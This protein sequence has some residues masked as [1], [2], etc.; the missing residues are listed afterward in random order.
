[1]NDFHRIYCNQLLNERPAFERQIQ[2]IACST[3]DLIGLFQH[4]QASSKK[5]VTTIDAWLH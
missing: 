3:T 5:G 2:P 4:T 1:M